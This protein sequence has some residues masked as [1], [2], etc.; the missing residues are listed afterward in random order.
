MLKIANKSHVPEGKTIAIDL[1]DGRSIALF[2]QNGQ[3]YALNN[4]CPHKGAPLNEGKVENGIVTCPWHCWKFD[5]K[6]G[7]CLSPEEAKVRSYKLFFE[8]DSIFIES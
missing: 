2:N 5:I 8:G 4:F 3:Y 6:S 1:P 7:E